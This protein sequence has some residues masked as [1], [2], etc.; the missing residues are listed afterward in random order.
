MASGLITK[1]DFQKMIFN[2]INLNRFNKINRLG[3]AVN[4][5]PESLALIGL[6]GECLPRE[7]LYAISV[8][9]NLNADH[10][11]K[12]MENSH[13]ISGLGVPIKLLDCD[14]KR[15]EGDLTSQKIIKNRLNSLIVQ[16][17][18]ENNISVIAFGNTL[19]DYLTH[20]LTEMF[21]QKAGYIH[22]LDVLSNLGVYGNRVMV[23]RP[24]LKYNMV[25]KRI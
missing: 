17:C 8:D 20:L 23:L 22:G 3:I 25:C 2:A 7:Y 5:K 19:E 24:L 6:L 4:H 21:S 12:M 16:E 13:K 15:V 18:I 1:H 14:W 11:R 10:S 9:L